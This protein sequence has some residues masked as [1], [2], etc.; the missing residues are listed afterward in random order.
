MGFPAK[1]PDAVTKLLGAWKTRAAT[2]RPAVG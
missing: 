1:T 2:G